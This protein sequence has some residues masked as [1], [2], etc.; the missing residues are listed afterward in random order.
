V[1][2]SWQ[3]HPDGRF[4]VQFKNISLPFR[5]FDGFQT[6]QPGAIVEDKWLSAALA[7]VRRCKTPIRSSGGAIVRC[8]NDRRTIWMGQGCRVRAE[9]QRCSIRRGGHLTARLRRRR[10]GHTQ[11]AGRF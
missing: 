10:F 2:L 3:D 1:P 7:V 9:P 6:V 11:G 4:A 5:V 8:R